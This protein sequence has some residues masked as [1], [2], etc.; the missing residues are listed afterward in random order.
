MNA[1]NLIIEFDENDQVTKDL[2]SEWLVA[3]G[4]N[5]FVDNTVVV[6]ANVPSIKFITDNEMKVHYD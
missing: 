5:I 4:F 3:E 6:L 2:F 1:K